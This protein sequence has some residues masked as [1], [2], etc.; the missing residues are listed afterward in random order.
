MSPACRGWGSDREQSKR[1]LGF[2][3]PV[4]SAWD[5]EASPLVRTPCSS[6]NTCTPG[7]VPKAS[8]APP[9]PDLQP[10]REVPSEQVIPHDVRG[11]SSCSHTV[12][13]ALFRA[14]DVQYLL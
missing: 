10:G 9:S 3:T 7:V 4:S 6:R 8:P 1:R 11:D 13:Q 5:S 14:L 2:K 12:C